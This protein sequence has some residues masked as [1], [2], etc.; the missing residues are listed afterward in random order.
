MNREAKYLVFDTETTGIDVFNDRIVQ[1]VAATADADGNLIDKWEWVINPGVPVPEEAAKVHGFTNEYL[2]EYG[3][4]PKQALSEVLDE[5]LDSYPLVWVAFNLNF[6]LSILESEFYRHLDI[7][8]WG[9][10]FSA[11]V[12]MFDPLVVDRKWDKYRKGK[13]PLEAMAGHYGVEF[14]PEKAHEAGYDVEITAKVAAKV[15]GAY[16]IPSTADQSAWYAEW[17]KGLQEYLRRTDPDAVVDSG[18][19]LGK[20]KG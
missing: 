15:A 17:A 3:V 18:W 6:D 19:P 11:K 2:S 8:E 7:P 1:L 14:D 10:E 16:G 12:Q 5:F 4:D 9:R 20:D 13:R